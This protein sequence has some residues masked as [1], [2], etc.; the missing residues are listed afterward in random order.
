V[1][2]LKGVT[3]TFTFTSSAEALKFIEILSKRLGKGS[4]LGEVKGNKVKV[5][6]PFR[7]DYRRLVE[8]VKHLYAEV[9]AGVS[10]RLK[11]FEI[12]T[13]LS[14]SNLRVAIPMQALL[15]ALQ[16][17]GY[18][19]ELTGSRIVT[20]ASFQHVVELAER[21]SEAYS[22]AVELRLPSPLRRIVAAAA[23]CAGFSVEET[24]KLLVSHGLVAHK[25]GGY[26]LLLKPEEAIRKLREILVEKL[27]R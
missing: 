17:E 24:L 4:F 23:A 26:L 22:E 7:E 2:A 14:A 8:E 18:R 5:F 25:E 16:L 21:V 20:N 6:I 12:T 19:A 11:S 9:H 1:G 13:V 10:R 3:L 15:E 27:R